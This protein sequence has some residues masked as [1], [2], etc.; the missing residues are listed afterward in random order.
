MMRQEMVENEDHLQEQWMNVQPIVKNS[1]VALRTQG[2]VTGQ[3]V[4]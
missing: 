2:K 4:R 3:Q 1:I